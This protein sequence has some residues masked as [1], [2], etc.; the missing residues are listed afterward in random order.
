M[1]KNALS[2]VFTIHGLICTAIQVSMITG[3]LTLYV[4]FQVQV[5]GK[6]VMIGSPD[7]PG[8]MSDTRGA[9]LGKH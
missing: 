8:A 1:L 3:V 4:V 2:N 6:D 5:M 7:Y 9:K